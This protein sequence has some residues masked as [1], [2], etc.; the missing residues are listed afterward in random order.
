MN[1]SIYNTGNMHKRNN[2]K[3]TKCTKTDHK[4][5]PKQSAIKFENVTYVTLIFRQFIIIYKLLYNLSNI[6]T[7]V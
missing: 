6:C 3:C 5:S 1:N 4:H 7:I 2:L